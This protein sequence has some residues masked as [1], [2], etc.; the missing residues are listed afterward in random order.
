M[1]GKRKREKEDLYD[2]KC[3]SR[4]LDEIEDRDEFMEEQRLSKSFVN[5]A[6]MENE[7]L[8]EKIN[9][10]FDT[11]VKYSKDSDI[12]MCERISMLDNIVL[13][14]FNFEEDF[15]AY[16]TV[17]LFVQWFFFFTLLPVLNSMEFTNFLLRENN[18][19]VFENE[20]ELDDYILSIYRNIPWCDIDNNIIDEDDISKITIHSATSNEGGGK[21]YRRKKKE[22]NDNNF[23]I[24]DGKNIFRFESRTPRKK[25]IFLDV[26]ESEEINKAM[27]DRSYE[28]RQSGRSEFELTRQK[29]QQDIDSSLID[30]VDINNDTATDSVSLSST[31][32][33]LKENSYTLT[34]EQ[35]R[36]LKL[37]NDHVLGGENADKNEY[38]RKIFGGGG[39]NRRLSIDRVAGAGKTFILETLLKKCYVRYLV[40]KKSLLQSTLA[41]FEDSRKKIYAQT[42]DAFLMQF[43]DIKCFDK[44]LILKETHL[45]TLIEKANEKAMV[46][47]YWTVY[48]IDEYS[49]I[50]ASLARLI[51]II[52]RKCRVILVRDCNRQSIG[53]AY[54]QPLRTLIGY[55]RI[56]F[57]YENVRAKDERLKNRLKIFYVDLEN[58]YKSSVIGLPSCSNVSIEKYVSSNFIFHILF[59]A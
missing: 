6:T 25:P 39:S 16:A 55:E 8:R 49:L 12:V 24:T 31:S 10:Y 53:E 23:S 41:R 38:K 9:N 20:K 35:K 15:C 34:E 59:L 46:H 54:D 2:D 11:K 58:T 22:R 29:D 17:S 50:E 51:N 37:I 1:L 19:Y 57:M 45:E 28:A 4:N 18:L 56:A 26:R 7:W 30:N 32:S 36:I 5:R 42:I 48:F 43:Y 52:L 44:W 21:R 13:H 40:K 27:Q 3:Q 33:S 14:R 47:D